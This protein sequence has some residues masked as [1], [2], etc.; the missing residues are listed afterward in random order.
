MTLPLPVQEHWID[1]AD[2][3]RLFCRDWLLLGATSA[4]Q[5][6]H[7]L[8]EH[9]GRYAALAHLFNAAGCSVRICDHRG[10]GN[11]GGRQGSLIQPDDLLRD[12]KQTFDD[13]SRRT[14]CTPLLFGHSMG[15]LVA[16]RFATGGFSPVRALA[17]SSPAL[18][19][20]L[21]GWQRLLLKV[22]SAIAPGLALPT[23]LPAERISHDPHEVRAYRQDPLN[24]G[25]IAPRMLNFMLDAMHHV[26][27]DAAQF[28]RPVLLQVAGD[29]A[30]VAPRGSRAFFEALPGER[31][32]LHWYASAYHE[33]F[34]EEAGLREQAMHDLREWLGQ[35][36]PAE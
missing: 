11:S 12:L 16:A 8:G 23:A 5:M 35:L 28:T 9:G 21:S 33:I 3:T 1:A 15:G 17:L 25:K 24:H 27:R 14:Q 32:T 10:H 19:L 13:F 7:G 4:V 2:G 30:F 36:P 22:S 34:N 20:D 31:K 6:V 26:A 29:D 18:A